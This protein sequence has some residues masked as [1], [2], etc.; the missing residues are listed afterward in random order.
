MAHIEVLLKNGKR[1]EGNG[2]VAQVIQW[3]GQIGRGETI[4][5]P[6]RNGT[7]RID[8]RA[9]RGCS[10]EIGELSL[11]DASAAMMAEPYTHYKTSDGVYQYSDMSRQFEKA[12]RRLGVVLWEV[13]A[14]PDKRYERVGRDSLL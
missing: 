11:G 14:L 4:S 13:A 2:S 8:G 12:E 3:R 9:V 1:V 6:T 5:L 7:Y 10:C